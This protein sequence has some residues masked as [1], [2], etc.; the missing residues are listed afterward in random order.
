MDLTMGHSV[1]KELAGWLHTKSHGQCLNVQ[2]E[3]SDEWLSS[4]VVTG[5]SVI[6]LL[7]QLDG[8]WD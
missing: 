6:L 4:G 7:C 1:G 3:T 2:P 8:Q 5:T